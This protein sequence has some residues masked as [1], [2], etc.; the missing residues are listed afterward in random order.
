MLIE[1]FSQDQNLNENDKINFTIQIELATYF[2]N[3]FKVWY[4]FNFLIL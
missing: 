3:L 1:L 4:F 2:T